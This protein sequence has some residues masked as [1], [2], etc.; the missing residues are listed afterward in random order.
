[1]QLQDAIGL[2]VAGNFAHHLEQAGELKDFENVVTA[3][4]DAPK[5]FFPFYLPGSDSFLGLY[6]IGTDRLDL[7]DFEANAQVEPE[8]AVLFDVIYDEKKEVIDL[9]AKK[10]TTFN[11]CTIRKEGAKKISEKKSWGA[12]SKG[13]GDRW[14][15]IDTFEEGGVMDN[16]HLCSFVKREGV[17]HPYGVDAPLLGY[18]YFYTKLK[19]WLVD[20]MNTQEDFGPL[21]DISAHLKATNYPKQ[22]L[23]SIGA[24]AYA[25][26]GE[27][28]YLKSGDEVYVIA[29]DSRKDASDLEPSEAKVILHQKVS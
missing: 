21:E 26:F 25:E 6:P 1:M 23:I 24:T 7:P 12:N 5:G 15:A 10:F 8:I 29:Y 9:I 17:L 27:K 4:A 19:T 16:Y 11:D 3:E 20:K 13:I 22:A 2:G 28:N 18:S 14:I